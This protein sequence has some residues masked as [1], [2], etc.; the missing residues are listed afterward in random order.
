LCDGEE[1]GHGEWVRGVRHGD[2]ADGH[3]GLDGGNFLFLLFL[4]LYY[5]HHSCS[6]QETGIERY[7]RDIRVHQILEGTNEIMHH[8]VGRS[9]VG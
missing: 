6:S 9:L 1:N 3:R 8:I 5:D 4:S 7:I 2:A